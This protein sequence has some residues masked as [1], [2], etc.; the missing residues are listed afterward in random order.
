M[1]NVPSMPVAV[2]QPVA[3]DRDPPLRRK[4]F[5]YDRI[6]VFIVLAIFLG[7]VTSHKKTDIP[8]MSWGEA[9]RDQLHA[10]WWVLVLAGIEIVRQIHNLISEH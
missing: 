10:K 9:L 3:D 8:L 6:K 2:H 5:F 7:L 1:M 4:V